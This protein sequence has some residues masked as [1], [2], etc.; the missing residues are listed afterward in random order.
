MVANREGSL[1]MK[2][3]KKRGGTPVSGFDGGAG[4]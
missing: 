1:S 4:Q 2:I 3:Y